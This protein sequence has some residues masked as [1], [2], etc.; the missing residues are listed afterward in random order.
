MKPMKRIGLKEIAAV[1]GTSVY[2]VSVALSGRGSVSAASRK[3]VQ[4]IAARLDYRP[5]RAGKI[6]QAPKNEN[7]GLL[8]TGRETMRRH[9][10]SIELN[11]H[12]INEC[13]RLGIYHQT[14][15]F[16]AHNATAN[17][18]PGL[19][20][21]GLM[22]GV[23][24]IGEP[25]PALCRLVEEPNALLPAV[26]VGTEGKYC[27]QFD[28]AA[29]TRETLEHFYALGHRRIAFLNGPEAFLVFGE[30]ARA[31]REFAGE[32]LSEPPDT[33]YW[34]MNDNVQNAM[35]WTREGLARLFL[36]PDPPTALLAAGGLMVKS[37]ILWLVMQ[38]FRVL[39]D[40]SVAVIESADWEAESFL[41]PVSAVEYNYEAVAKEAIGL[42]RRLMTDAGAPKDPVKIRVPQ[43][44]VLRDT[45]APAKPSPGE[46]RAPG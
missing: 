41:L 34:A 23:I 37:V 38:G 30:A 31:Y 21:D 33:H 26:Y 2:T 13:N 17:S 12:F 10:G 42:L 32:R 45:I 25:F 36:R 7:I 9:I 4:E 18:L 8:I 43:K 35:A 11:F 39:A 19:L 40:V 5:N 27:V 14:E 44:L 15:W 6:L 46:G 28:T 20:T 29:A 1:A 3:R 22:G 24:V 16:D